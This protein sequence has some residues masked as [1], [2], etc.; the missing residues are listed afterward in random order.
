MQTKGE[1]GQKISGLRAFAEMEV[2]ACLRAE[3]E[4]PC[5]AQGSGTGEETGWLL[6]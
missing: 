4:A 6:K 2:S 3:S 1:R 5:G